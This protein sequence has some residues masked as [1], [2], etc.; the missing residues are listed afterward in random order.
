MNMKRI[1]SMEI[2][3][4]KSPEEILLCWEVMREL[5]PHLVR[6]EF[7]PLVT[8]MIGEGYVLAYILDDGGKDGPGARAAAA[9]GFRVLTFL[10]HGAHIYIDDLSTLPGCRKKGYGGR[11]LD[12]VFN[13]AKEKGLEVVTL[14]SGPARHDAH[15]LYLN[16]GFSIASYHFVRTSRGE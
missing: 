15:R 5:R 1:D 7:V 10:L 9:V 13:L 8:K 14:D 3:I 16:R 12:Y 4:A 2:R 6:K 11:L